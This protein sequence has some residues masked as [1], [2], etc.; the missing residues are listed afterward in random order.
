MRAQD[1]RAIAVAEKKAAEAR[2]AE[3]DKRWNAAKLA[4]GAF[5]FDTGATGSILWDQLKDVIG[6]RAWSAAFNRAR[7]E[8]EEEDDDSS[9]ER[10]PDASGGLSA[11]DAAVQVAEMPTIREIVKVQL[12]AAGEAGIK[13]STIREFIL[14]VYHQ[15]VHEKTVGMTLYRLSKDGL[16]RREGHTWFSAKPGAET[17]NPGGDTPGS[18]DD[19]LGNGGA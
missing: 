16:A 2:L 6:E 10:D 13:A 9:G 17:E 8:P 4:F 14:Q 15:T 19:Q 11:A 12:G 1:E 5:G 3:A 7:G 18:E